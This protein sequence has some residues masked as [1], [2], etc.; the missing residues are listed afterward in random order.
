M[1]LTSFC[2]F[3]AVLR[4][5]KCWGKKSAHNVFYCI[6]NKYVASGKG[7]WWD[8]LWFS[9]L[10]FRYFTQDAMKSHCM[11]MSAK[12]QM[13]PKFSFCHLSLFCV[14]LSGTFVSVTFP[15]C[16]FCT[17]LPL[18]RYMPFL[19]YTSPKTSLSCVLCWSTP[20]IRC[21]P[22]LF[23]HPCGG[24]HLCA[25]IS[26]MAKSSGSPLFSPCPTSFIH[27]H[28]AYACH[29]IIHTTWP[30]YHKVDRAQFRWS[31]LSSTASVSDVADVVSSWNSFLGTGWA[32][33]R[34]SLALISWARG[35]LSSSLCCW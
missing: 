5:P 14:T 20:F 31:P 1:I 29:S 9:I 13:C 32:Q 34:S 24:R 35:T 8:G 25:Y 16:F 11:A 19:N 23:W 22:F 2:L 12:A 26:S 10:W 17:C 33:L 18:L 15:D 21:F 27:T 7:F 4:Y 30:K 3:K 6:Y 28:G